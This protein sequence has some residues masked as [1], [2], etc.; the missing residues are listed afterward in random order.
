MDDAWTVCST[1]HDVFGSHPGTVVFGWNMLF[2]LTF[3]TAGRPGTKRIQ[4]KNVALAINRLHK[5]N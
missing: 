5:C 2:D 1:D 3:L 4:L